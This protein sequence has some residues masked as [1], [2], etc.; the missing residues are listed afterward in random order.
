MSRFNRGVGDDV[1]DGTGTLLRE[2]APF[3]LAGLLLLILLEWWV[4]YGRPLPG[5]RRIEVRT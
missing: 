4:A 3:L 2:W 1:A 5:R